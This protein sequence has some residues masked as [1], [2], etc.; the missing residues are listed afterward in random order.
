M[1][2]FDTLLMIVYGLACYA[3]GRWHQAQ[4]MIQ[5]L[6]SNSDRIREIL[7]NLHNE[8]ADD[9]P[10]G[11]RIPIRAEWVGDQ[12][13]L[14]VDKTGEFLAQGPDVDTAIDRITKFTP[15]CDYVLPKE[16]ATKPRTTQP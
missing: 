12:V 15:G 7:N 14:Y 3:V 5:R 6:L 1:T 11:E 2:E 9:D 8:T 4:I 16:M 13:Y 10:A